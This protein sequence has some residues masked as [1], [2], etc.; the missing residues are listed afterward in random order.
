MRGN[1]RSRIGR[2]IDPQ[3][4]KMLV[5]KID[6][7]LAIC[8]DPRDVDRV[9]DVPADRFDDARRDDHNEIGMGGKEC[10]RQKLLDI[11]PAGYACCPREADEIAHGVD[12]L[13]L[14][15]EILGDRRTMRARERRVA[16]L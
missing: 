9:A 3:H 10:I 2:N 13:L 14:R 5:G 6:M 7:S 4:E 1:G 11:P 12:P 15:L 8:F 16:A